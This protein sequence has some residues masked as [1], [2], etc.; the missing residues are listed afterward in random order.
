MTSALQATGIALR[1]GEHPVLRGVDLTVG[2]GECVALLGANGAGKTTLLRVLSTLL[3]PD[4]GTVRICGREALREP[5]WARRRLGVVGHALHLYEDLTPAENLVLYGRLYGVQRPQERAKE[6]LAQMGLERVG[7][8]PLRRLSR[9]QR[10]RLAL[11][12]SL[13]HRPP[14][15]L[16]DEPETGLDPQGQM[17]LHRL[18]ASQ[19]AAG[20]AVVWTTHRVADALRVSHRAFVLVGGRLE[21][22]GSEEEAAARLLG[23][24]GG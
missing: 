19:V 3:R 17:L 6:L 12:R 20:R 16:W 5:A 4:R 14:I 23:G 2:E 10:Q 24:E 7:G 1:Y 13:V 8:L 9:G 22:A 18:L 15:L 21:P 11:A